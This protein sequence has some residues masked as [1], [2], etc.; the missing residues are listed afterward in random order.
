[1]IRS[2][3]QRHA[4]QRGAKLAFAGLAALL[5]AQLATPANAAAHLNQISAYH[6]GRA[7]PPP[8]RLT[9][10]T[11]QPRGGR[12]PKLQRNFS[13]APPPLPTG[14]RLSI[15]LDGVSRPAFSEPPVGEYLTEPV[16]Y[17]DGPQSKSSR[18]LTGLPIDR[19]YRAG[20]D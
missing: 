15:R 16:E 11:L 9:R 17:R 3:N 20:R 12:R 10:P 5:A 8:P 6:L 18:K 1:M 7:L 19:T 4:S 13:I 2:G 14:R